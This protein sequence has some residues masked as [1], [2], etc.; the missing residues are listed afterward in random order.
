M[1]Q[2]AETDALTGLGNH[3]AFQLELGRQIEAAAS[4]TTAK[5]R[6]LAVLMMDLDA[7]KSYNDRHGHPAGDALLHDVAT[8]IYGAA[9]SGDR[10]FRYGGDEFAI[11]LPGPTVA[12]AARVAERIRAAVGAPDRRVGRAR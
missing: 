2:R 9:R 5:S 12:D 4:A 10:V 6:R 1:S 3:G 11:I 8:A 7:F